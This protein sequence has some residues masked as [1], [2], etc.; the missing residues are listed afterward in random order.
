MQEIVLYPSGCGCG[1]GGVHIN[2]Y[3]GACRRRREP[4]FG[5]I[6]ETGCALIQQEMDGSIVTGPITLR[7]DVENLE[8]IAEPEI[9]AVTYLGIDGEPIAQPNVGEPFYISVPATDTSYL[10][11]LFAAV[12]N[13][14]DASGA[15]L[16]LHRANR[17]QTL[18]QMALY[19][20]VRRREEVQISS[21]SLLPPCYLV[22][23]Q[24][25]FYINPKPIPCHCG[26]GCVNAAIAGAVMDSAFSVP[27]CRCWQD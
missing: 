17:A 26:C 9:G 24:M 22:Y 11:R 4:D 10:V 1:C 5:V 23:A 12:N 14:T 19:S 27:C 20:G 16:D 6:F 8:I 13:C 25:S 7:A 21:D 18:A 3:G 15:Q 2:Y